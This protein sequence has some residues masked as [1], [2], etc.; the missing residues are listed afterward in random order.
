MEI[1][2]QILLKVML[3]L[4]FVIRLFRKYAV[5]CYRRVAEL[6][7]DNIV[8]R[9]SRLRFFAMYEYPTH[10]ITHV[11]LRDQ[12]CAAILTL[13]SVTYTCYCYRARGP[14]A[15]DGR[16]EHEADVR[17]VPVAQAAGEAADGHASGA[18]DA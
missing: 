5:P 13:L 18:G 11:S 15:R 14:A 12:I 10:F 4:C 16:H 9:Q 6:I 3:Q 2:Q 8:E 17:D 7:R 1:G